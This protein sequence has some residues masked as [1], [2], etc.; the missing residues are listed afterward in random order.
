MRLMMSGNLIVH[1]PV[2]VCIVTICGRF[3]SV[4][5]IFSE[6]E[7]FEEYTYL[8]QAVACETYLL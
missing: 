3:V 8:D 2:L 7:V 6:Y 4:V 5:V 1:C